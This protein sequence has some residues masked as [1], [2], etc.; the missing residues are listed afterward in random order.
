MLR[1]FQMFLFFFCTLHT[2]IQYFKM[3]NQKEKLV[4]FLRLKEILHKY[5][6]HLSKEQHIKIAYINREK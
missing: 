6:L 5:V 1:F 4:I 2:Y 3:K